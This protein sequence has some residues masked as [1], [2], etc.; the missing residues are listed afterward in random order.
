MIRQAN[1]P[2]APRIAPIWNHVI[3]ETVATFNSVEKTEAEVAGIIQTRQ[4]AGHA[5]LVAESNGAIL[6]FATYDQFRGGIGYRRTMEH[7]I[8]VAP[9]AFGLGLGRALM[10]AMEDH[11]RQAG[12]HAM[13]GAVSAQNT[14]GRDFHLALGYLIVGR[15][16]EVGHKFGQYMDLLLLQKILT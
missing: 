13:V 9:H 3:R 12:V 14:D 8:L 16:P 1:A 11:A 10:T 6:G 2:D 5:F 7:T 15:M 4:A